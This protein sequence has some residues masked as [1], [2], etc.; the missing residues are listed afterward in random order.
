MLR[1][2]ARARPQERTVG[3]PAPTVSPRET[4]IAGWLTVLSALPAGEATI[5]DVARAA[6]LERIDQATTMIIG[7]ALSRAGWRFAYRRGSGLRERVYRR[8]VTAG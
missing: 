2:T 8:E 6:G 3:P 5:R 7:E 1:G 4:T